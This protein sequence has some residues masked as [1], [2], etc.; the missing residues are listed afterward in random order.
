MEPMIRPSHRA[1][2]K[3][4]IPLPLGEGLGEG[5]GIRLRPGRVLRSMPLL[6]LTLAALLASGPAGA[7]GLREAKTLFD[8]LDSSDL[9]VRAAIGDVAMREKPRM[10]VADVEVRE[11]VKGAG[12]EKK[13]R[14]AQELFFQSD[15]PA[16]RKGSG[17]IL[18]LTALPDDSQWNKARR[19]G[20]RYLAAERGGGVKIMDP[21]SLAAVTAFLRR[22]EEL[23]PARSA[24]DEKVQRRLLDLFLEGL[25]SPVSLLQDASAAAIEDLPISS[26]AT[27][28][29]RAA[30]KR[31]IRDSSRSRL[32]RGG[33]LGHLSFLDDFDAVLSGIILGE[34]E[35]RLAALEAVRASGG[36][37][38]ISRECLEA[39]LR[40]AD[41]EV[42][43]EALA[44][45]SSAPN[46]GKGEGEL[47]GAIATG[48]V[49]PEVRASAMAV[50]GARRGE[51]DILSRGLEDQSPYVVY[52]AAD[53][54]RRMGDEES[55][56]VLGDLLRSES[57]KS[58]FIGILMLGSMEGDPAREILREA[59]QSHS[60][61]WTRHL[62][63]QVLTVGGL[64]AD[65]FRKVLG[66]GK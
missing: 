49:S 27:R 64:D 37:M 51:V 12:G 30:L 25:E 59:S 17:A 32:A 40:D 3:P 34:P 22:Y 26:M 62:C 38:K 63:S 61:P 42:R 5:I 47:L 24:D 46:G 56:Q 31:F 57:E 41:E 19:E 54:L 66:L 1:F 13:L 2:R 11:V 52:T 29:D 35:M 33:L 7:A 16:F 39:C 18:F 36:G 21:V 20:V 15:E 55:V 4:S 58:R 14:A 10:C 43:L 65:S 23:G 6:V 50:V 8:L 53:A 45:L 9:V 60:D 48:D 28:R 44:L